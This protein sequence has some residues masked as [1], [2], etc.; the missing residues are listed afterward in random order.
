MSV[1]CVETRN[2]V[3]R[4][5]CLLRRRIARYRGK[6]Q[7]PLT[8]RLIFC[9]RELHS[10]SRASHSLSA[11]QTDCSLLRQ[12]SNAAMRRL[13]FCSRTL[14]YFGGGEATVILAEMCY[15]RMS[16]YVVKYSKRIVKGN[17]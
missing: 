4:T 7:M 10:Q 3:L 15:G 1:K 8:R 11:L 16:L 5:H 17:L 14:Y 2:S 13:I 6:N 12:K 9:S